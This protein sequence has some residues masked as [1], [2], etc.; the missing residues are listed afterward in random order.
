MLQSTLAKIVLTGALVLGGG[1]FLVYSSLDD[2]QYYEMVD[3]V[4]QDPGNYL[5]KDLKLHGFVVVGSIHHEQQMLHTFT[6]EMNGQRID[7]EYHGEAPD[8]LKDRAEVVAHGRLTQDAS[9]HLLLTSS[10][11]MAK[12]PSKYQGSTAN[13]DLFGK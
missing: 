1:G 7:I 13:K 5:D 4:A 3:K 10:E 12:C 6:L 11:L 8:N 9:G 2:A